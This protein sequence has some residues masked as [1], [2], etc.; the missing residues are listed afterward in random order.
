MKPLR[1]PSST[2]FCLCSARGHI[3]TLVRPHGQVQAV[4]LSSATLLQETEFVDRE[5]QP[6]PGGILVLSNY[7]QDALG[8]LPEIRL[9]HCTIH[10]EHVDLQWFKPSGAWK[11]LSGL[12]T[13]ELYDHFAAVCN[14]IA[15]AWSQNGFDVTTCFYSPLVLTSKLKVARWRAGRIERNQNDNAL[16]FA[17]EKPMASNSKPTGKSAPSKPTGKPASSKSAPSKPSPQKATKAQREQVEDRFQEAIDAGLVEVVNFRIIP[18]EKRR[19]LTVGFF[20]VRVAGALVTNDWRYCEGNNGPFVEG[21]QKTRVVDDETVY[22]SV[23]LTTTR[24]A[25][26]ALIALA[27]AA[28]EEA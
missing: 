28:Y 5:A 21:A 7:G 18:E 3:A 23:N 19:G 15:K 22:E 6:F 2:G 26:E 27:T 13:E 1:L 8:Y 17:K 11:D 24:E 14:T 16:P 20:Q 12:S 9:Q 25:R 4:D 10:D